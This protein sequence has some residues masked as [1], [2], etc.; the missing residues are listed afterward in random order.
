M[1][2][3]HFDIHV[4]S[5]WSQDTRLEVEQE[6]KLAYLW[7]P[8]NGIV[9]IRELLKSRSVWLVDE[10]GVMHVCVCVLWLNGV[11]MASA[12]SET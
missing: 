8:K 3:P 9:H 4:L 1:S 11:L 6:P 12:D 5:G 2:P 10:G 7:E